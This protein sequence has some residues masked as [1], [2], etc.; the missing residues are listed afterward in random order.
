MLAFITGNALNK[1]FTLSS[2]Y[3]RRKSTWS[4]DIPD[5]EDSSH[6]TVSTTGTYLSK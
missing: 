2:M 3:P 6:P 4:A 1:I 5:L